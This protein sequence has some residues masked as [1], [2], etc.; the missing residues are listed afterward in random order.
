MKTII[1][2]I[3][4]AWLFAIPITAQA[5]W[6]RLAP[7]AYGILIL[8]DKYEEHQKE[9]MLRHKMDDDMRYREFVKGINTHNDV[10]NPYRSSRN[11]ILSGYN[12]S[13]VELLINNMNPNSEMAKAFRRSA[14]NHVSDNN[15]MKEINLQTKIT[16]TFNAL[17]RKKPDIYLAENEYIITN[18]ILNDLKKEGKFNLTEKQITAR[19]NYCN[20]SLP[21]ISKTKPTVE[22]EK[23]K[24]IPVEINYEQKQASP[25]PHEPTQIPAKVDVEQQQKPKPEKSGSLAWFIVA[26]LGLIAAIYGANRLLSP[27]SSPF[28]QVENETDFSP[29]TTVENENN[30][31]PKKETVGNAE[32]VFD[33]TKG[34]RALDIKHEG[35][36]WLILK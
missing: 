6:S 29:F 2:T 35:P 11:D 34:K 23:T 13:E 28:I 8:H 26:I 16:K 21:K 17:N 9:E 19:I 25:I 12:N 36:N 14:N 15:E 1:Y 32:P 3:I 10:L 18:Q 24:P 20:K 33:A 7:L 5:Q 27:T 22:P 30:I 31:P 4:T